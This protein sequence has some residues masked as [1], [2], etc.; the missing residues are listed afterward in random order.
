MREVSEFEFPPARPISGAKGAQ[1]TDKHESESVFIFIKVNINI[2]V[3]S[4]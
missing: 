3:S 2:W 4:E 1:R